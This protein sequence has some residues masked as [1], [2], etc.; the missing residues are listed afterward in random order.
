MGLR[1]YQIAAKNATYA[2]W[3]AGHRN[4]LMVQPTGGGKTRTFS[5]IISEFNGPSVAIAHR[6]ELVSQISLALGGYGV[7]HN[8]IAPEKTIRNIETL[9][10]QKLGRRWVDRRA[11]TNVAGV[12]TLIRMDENDPLFKRTGLWVVDECH[13]NLKKNKWGRAVEMFPNAYGL[14]VTATPIRADGCG[15]GS[16]ADGVFD[17]MIMG[18]SPRALI[19]AG[20]LTDYRIFAP[21]SDLDLTNVDVGASGEYVAQQLRD[22]VHK[23]HITGDVVSNYLKIAPGKLAIVFAVDVEHA[24][25]ISRAFRDAGVIS[26]VVSGKTPDILRAEIMRRFEA[27]EVSVL[28]NVDLFGEGVDVPAVEVVIMARPT[29]SFSL[30]CLDPETEVL[31]PKGW[32]KSD[33]ALMCDE[34]IAFDMSNASCQV[35]KVL[36]SVRRGLLPEESMYGINSPHMDVSVSDKHDM[37]VMGASGTCTNWI[38]QTAKSVSERK[39]LFKVPVAAFGEYQG[40]GLTESELRLIGWVQSDGTV[41]RITNGLYITQAIYKLSHIN[42]IRES[43]VGSG[44]KFAERVIVR[45]NVPET[46]ANLVQFSASFGKPRGSQKHLTGYS[47]LASW[48]DKSLPECFDTLTRNEL[49]TMLET[50]NLGDGKNDLSGLDYN[51][52]S[53]VIACGDNER[54]ADRLQALCVTRGLRCNKSVQRTVGRK[55]WFTLHIK[56]VAY[57]TIA[58]TGVSDGDIC[59]RKYTRSRFAKRDAKP[60]FVWCLTNRLGTLI[61]RRNG[62]VAIVG[63]CQQA[64]RAL[65]LN[66]SKVLMGAWDTY[67]P[68]QRLRFIAE[69]EKPVAFIIDH[70]K[71]WQR[72]GLFDAE[73]TYTL[74]RRERRTRNSMPDSIPTRTC[75]NVPESTGVICMNVYERTEKY[76]PACGCKPEPAA[77]S[78]PEFVD[79]DLY[80]LDLNALRFLRGEADKIMGAPAIPHGATDIIAQAIRNRHKEKQ[81]AQVTLREL[82]AQWGGVQVHKG[83]NDPS[84]QQRLFYLTFGID[85]LSAQALPRKEA[86]DLTDKIIKR[87]A[88]DMSVNKDQTAV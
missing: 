25:E 43:L 3:Q 31:T 13:H 53:M 10:M 79:G 46:H 51:M 62:K 11:H 32:L 45:K 38:K 2:A 87:I 36:G 86:E 4:V 26:E 64:G 67:T 19:N 35:E 33:E 9:H 14:G 61:T 48:F 47:K 78:A 74:D 57:S 27:R 55:P 28:V 71:N 76:C 15:L 41:N 50:W 5:E 20:Y 83:H 88:I 54:M 81:S 42:S 58:G 18:P 77:R 8:I 70:V 49:L 65:R 60:D 75:T 7:R 56:D 34:V 37:I 72:H 44:I 24:T 22:A 16:H 12:D 84:Y 82:M 80:E 30:Y 17:T 85:V 6:Q 59:G 40:S 63:N 1:P 68:E 21:Q 23:S 69:S 66:I 39:S 73:R 29:Q 52:R